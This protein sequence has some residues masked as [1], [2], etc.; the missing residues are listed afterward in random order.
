MKACYADG[1]LS[2]NLQ[3]SLQTNWR[4]GLGGAGRIRN[5]G[6]ARNRCAGNLGQYWGNFGLKFASILRRASSPSVRYEFRRQLKFRCRE[7]A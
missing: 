4:V 6:V 2:G 1:R 5:I 3:I 7:N